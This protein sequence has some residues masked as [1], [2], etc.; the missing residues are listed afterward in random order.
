MESRD[1]K[2]LGRAELIEIIYQ[3][4]K[5]EEELQSEN[6]KLKAALDDKTVNI[7]NLGSVAEA[8]L[9]L[10][11]IFNDAQAAAD[12]YLAEVKRRHDETD[13]QCAAI[14]AKAQAEADSVIAAALKQKA[15]IEQQCKVSRAELRRVKEVLQALNDEIAFDK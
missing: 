9:A 5:S 7:A 1:I 13:A 11:G 14:I 3:L 4:K 12:N 2:K 8:S 6:A 10:S 15:L